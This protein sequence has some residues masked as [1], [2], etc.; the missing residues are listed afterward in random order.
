MGSAFSGRGTSLVEGES[1]R[2]K[3]DIVGGRGTS[4]VEE[5]RRWWEGDVFG[6]TMDFP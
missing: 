4:L 2:L 6:E 5:G 1:R 3:R